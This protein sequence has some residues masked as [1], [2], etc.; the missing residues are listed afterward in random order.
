MIALAWTTMAAAQVVTYRG[1]LEA[2]ATIFPQEAVNDPERLIGDARARLDVFVKPAGWMLLEGGL[3]GLGN[4]YGQVEGGGLNITDRGLRR[5][6]LALRRLNVTLTRRALTVQA[7]KQVVRWGKT[8]VVTPTDRFAPRDFLSVIDADSLAVRAVR[9]AVATRSDTV[10][11]VVSVFTPSRTPLLDQRWTVRPAGVGPVAFDDRGSRFPSRLQ[12]G[13][14]WSHIGR[15][16]EYSVSFFDGFNHLPNIDLAAALPVGTPAA[17]APLV[18]S[19]IRTFPTLRMYGADTA[20]PTAW[21]TLKGEVAYFR[22]QTAGTDEYVLYVV[23][24][25]RQTGE[26]LLIGG[27]AGE[28]VTDARALANFAPDRGSARAFVG[29]ASYTIDPNRSAAVEAAVR[30]SGTGVYVKGEFSEAVGRHW[31]ATLTGAVI[32]GEAGDFLGQYRRNSH[33]GLSL[34][35]SF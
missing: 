25:E 27:Y 12:A 10:E 18:V 28:I 1:S 7:G 32:G 8:D 26:W 31:R 23:Q 13:L 3:E 29:R 16:H 24:L 15:G 6:A 17:G 19:L 35:F 21:F 4:T 14:R 34:R 22:T 20:L 33:I 5:P 2:R 9:A 30:Q 11:G